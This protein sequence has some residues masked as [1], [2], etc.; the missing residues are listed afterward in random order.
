M[1]GTTLAHAY[2][3]SPGGGTFLEFGGSSDYLHKDWLGNARIA[4]LIS[5]QTVSADMAYAPYGEVYNVL[6]GSTTDQIFKGDLTQLDA[7]VLF[8]TP[9]RELAAANQG[10]WLS[11]D[12]A[13]QGWNQYAYSTNPNSAI[14]PSGLASTGNVS[15]LQPALDLGGGLDW[16]AYGLDGGFGVSGA[17]NG[18]CSACSSMVPN[19]FTG[20]MQ[21]LAGP[22]LGVAS[23]IF[24]SFPEDPNPDTANDA[25]S[26]EDVNPETDWERAIEPTDSVT[27]SI[28]WPPPGAYSAANP[29]PLSS[30]PPQYA[31]SFDWYIEVTLST[32]T[33][34]YRAWGDP[35]GMTGSGAGTF[36][37]YFDPGDLSTDLY[38]DQFSLPSKWNS[39]TNLDAVTIPAGTSV[40]L[41]PAASQQGYSY[42]GGGLQVFVLNP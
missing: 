15:I 38:R 26:P 29:G 9:N 5:A 2:L 19:L 37:S 10:R 24:Q 6:G 40:F 33:T 31:D 28:G 1:S 3:G 34:Y 23:A 11:P 14:D 7:G 22:L 35:A 21:Q 20:Q 13:G 17:D 4:S 39:L 12:P 41:G 16:A 36:Y 25:D 18:G 27:T 32:D 8:D 42:P 30:L